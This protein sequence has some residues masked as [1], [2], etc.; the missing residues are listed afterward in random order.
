MWQQG[1]PQHLNLEQEPALSNAP[2][3]Q[4]PLPPP[5][6]A[7]AAATGQP[8]NL[9]QVC[10]QPLGL[11]FFSSPFLVSA[12]AATATATAGR[13]WARCR[14]WPGWRCGWS[15][16]VSTPRQQSDRPIKGAGVAEPYAHSA[17]YPAACCRESSTCANTF[18]KSRGAIKYVR[19]EWRRERGCRRGTSGGASCERYAG[20][21]SSH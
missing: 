2:A 16:P 8:Q 18:S 9:F 14:C 17:T 4:A 19:R 3:Q 15:R 1:I 12:R 21:T 7:A 20:G 10:P 13:R 6:T 5:A 11:R